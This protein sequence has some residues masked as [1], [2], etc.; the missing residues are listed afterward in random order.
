MTYAIGQTI[1]A[2]EFNGIINGGTAAV[3]GAA[4]NAG[5]NATWNDGTAGTLTP[6]AALVL[7]RSYGYG[8]T[9]IPPVVVGATIKAGPLAG[10][11]EW[12]TAVDAVNTAAQHQTGVSPI[13]AANFNTP[14][15]AGASAT[16]PIAAPTLPGVITWADN[17]ITQ[18]NNIT[19]STQRLNSNYPGAWA[20]IGTITNNAGTWV[21]KLVLR[22]VVNFGSDAA[23]RYFFNAGGQF[24]ISG[25]HPAAG[26]NSVNYLIQDLF[27]DLGTVTLSS[28]NGTPATVSIG[29]TAFT[30][31]QQTGG[32]PA[33][34]TP[35]ANNG[36][37]AIPTALTLCFTQLADYPYHAYTAA[38]NIKL[39]ISYDL[40]GS[41]TF[42]IEV[43]EI[44]NG[45]TVSVGTTSNLSWRPP[46]HTGNGGVLVDTWGTPTVTSTV[47]SRV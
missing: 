41:L 2:A 25:S 10:P 17:L 31:I 12:R 38:T 24:S 3:L 29:G 33:G 44:P 39:F 20:Q 47:V 45:A 4:V 27:V 6:P 8:Q 26:A 36:F 1:R 37:Y 13:T 14:A 40:A 35:V 18:V 11:I 22:H 30:G 46:L 32:R 16:L 19:A 23:A 34:A 15:R 9:V 28:T 7:P 21:D 42:Q 43:D 5:I